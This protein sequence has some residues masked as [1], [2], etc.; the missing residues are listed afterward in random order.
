MFILLVPTQNNTCAESFVTLFTLVL[1]WT[2]VSPQVPCK[3][4]R[5]VEVHPAVWALQNQTP[6]VIN[7]LGWIQTQFLGNC[8]K[9]HKA[10]PSRLKRRMR[11]ASERERTVAAEK[12]ACRKIC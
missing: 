1:R 2:L 9:L 6:E 12:V 3:L 4:L 8:H 11:R 10:S 5:S 7:D